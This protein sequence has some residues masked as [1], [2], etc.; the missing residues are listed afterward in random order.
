M[1]DSHGA[2]LDGVSTFSGGT[3]LRTDILEQDRA[4]NPAFSI[5]LNRKKVKYKCNVPLL[6]LTG[7]LTKFANLHILSFV[8]IFKVILYS[9]TLV[10]LFANTFKV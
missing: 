4:F 3:T 5:L 6:F 1:I 7:K 10:P 8:N 2:V 9:T